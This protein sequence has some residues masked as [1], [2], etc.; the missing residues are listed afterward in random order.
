[1][2]GHPKS[3]YRLARCF[4]KGFVGDQVNL[5]LAAAWN[6]RKWLR[7]SALFLA[8]NPAHVV[9]PNGAPLLLRQSVKRFFRI[10]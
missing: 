1:M 7:A 10:D 6:L 3:Q 8:L 5:Q 4:L 2:I 9:Y